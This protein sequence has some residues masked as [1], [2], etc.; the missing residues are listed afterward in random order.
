[1]VQ[2]YRS[3]RRKAYHKPYHKPYHTAYHEAYHKRRVFGGRAVLLPASD[4]DHPLLV[5]LHRQPQRPAE[6]RQLYYLLP[7]APDRLPQPQI[8]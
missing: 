5:L 3:M 1:M 7:R 6:K 2:L 8:K 4:D